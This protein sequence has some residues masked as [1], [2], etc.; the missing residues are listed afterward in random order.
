MSR[1]RHLP[2]AL[3]LACA[4]TMTGCADE[5]GGSADAPAPT[6]GSAGSVQHKNPDDAVQAF[7]RALGHQD[8]ETACRVM[9]AGGQVIESEPDAFEM[10]RHAMSQAAAAASQQ[11]GDELKQATVRG[12]NVNGDNADLSTATTTPAAA[13]AMVQGMTAVR[14]GGAWYVTA[15]Q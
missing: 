10:C 4:L 12:A 1:A 11:F 3:A 15:P 7:L 9:A 5:T 14:L 6:A 8:S 13:S 2:A